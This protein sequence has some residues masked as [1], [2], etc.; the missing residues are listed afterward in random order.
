MAAVPIN[1]NIT[2]PRHSRILPTIMLIIH[3]FTIHT[4]H[5]FAS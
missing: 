2:T 1:N 4:Y 5:I 3:K